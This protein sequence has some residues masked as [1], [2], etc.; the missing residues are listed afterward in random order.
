MTGKFLKLATAGCEF[1]SR[2]DWRDKTGGFQDTRSF[3]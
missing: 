2:L 1:A 3:P